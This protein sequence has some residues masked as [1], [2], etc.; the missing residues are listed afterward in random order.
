MQEMTI[1]SVT[2]LLLKLVYR[3]LLANVLTELHS[4]PENNAEFEF[5]NEQSIDIFALQFRDNRTLV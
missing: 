4:N 3:H 1:E 2:V 5:A